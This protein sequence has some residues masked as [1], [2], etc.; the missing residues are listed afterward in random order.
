MFHR[1]E[2][3]LH[4]EIQSFGHPCAALLRFAVAVLAYNILSVLKRGIEHAHQ[5]TVPDF[6]VSTHYLVTEIIT[7]Y[8]GMLI[9]LPPAHWTS[10]AGVRPLASARRLLE[11]ARHVDKNTSVSISVVPGSELPKRMLIALPSVPMS[12]P[13]ECSRSQGH[14]DLERAG[15]EG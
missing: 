10:W 14:T 3:V 8:Q 2:A 12:R 11:R 4:S 13:R 5:D 15:P 6:N 9:A 1:L 7:G